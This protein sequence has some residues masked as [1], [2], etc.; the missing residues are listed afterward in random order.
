MYVSIKKPKWSGAMNTKPK[1]SHRHYEYAAKF[2]VRSIPGEQYRNDIAEEFADMF[3]E[4]AGAT[5]DRKK[6]FAACEVLEWRS[7]Q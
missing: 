1:F 2:L 5:F 3:T 6:F 4:D 7:R